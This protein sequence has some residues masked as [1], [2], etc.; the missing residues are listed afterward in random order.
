[1]IP[2]VEPLV[3]GVR[4][5]LRPRGHRM[6]CRDN[7]AMR[8]VMR[9]VLRSDSVCV[10]VGCHAGAILGDMI[11]MAPRAT[12][13]AIEPIPS[14]AAALRERFPDVIVHEVAASDATGESTFHLVETN[15]GYSGLRQR[16]FDRPDERVRTIKVRTARLDDL[17]ADVPRV[18][19]LKVDVEGAELQVFRGARET[20]RRHRPYVLFE[21]GLGAADVYG[22]TPA[23]LYAL[24]AECGLS[25]FLLDGVGPLSLAELE[26][27][28]ADNTCWN[29][30]ARPW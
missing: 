18:D 14:A 16:A 4:H 1:M 2:R 17:L 28:F 10:D 23:M 22:T 30:L 29:F 3:N 6:D 5:F 9:Y 15:P 13:H 26:R 12:H 27:A 19:L 25:V 11:E 20:L 21:H 8:A 24:L 7:A